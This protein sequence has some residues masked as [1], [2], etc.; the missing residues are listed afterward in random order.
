MLVRRL[1]MSACAI[2]T[3]LMSSVTRAADTRAM[4][5][6]ILDAVRTLRGTVVSAVPAGRATATYERREDLLKFDL[7]EVIPK[8][9]AVIAFAGETS[10]VVHYA[11][12]DKTVNRVELWNSD[13][14][15]DY[16]AAEKGS[17]GSVRIVRTIKRS[18]RPDLTGWHYKDIAKIPNND[19]DGEFFADLKRYPNL[20]VLRDGQSVKVVAVYPIAPE[21]KHLVMANAL[22]Y[23]FDMRY[24][25]MLNRFRHV[26]KGVSTTH[27]GEKRIREVDQV[28]TLSWRKA[29]NGAI[30]PVQRIATTITKSDAGAITHRVTS[31]I[32][33]ADFAL[34]PVS[35]DELTMDRMG[36]PKDTVV[37]D[38]LS[39]LRWKYFPG[40]GAVR[41]S[42]TSKPVV[43]RK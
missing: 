24:G 38:S 33:F 27:T 21:Y 30:L 11:A 6:K 39:G 20:K 23:E 18:F 9:R 16:V 43:E 28:V 40:A 34:E 17:T 35:E 41:R 25:G 10:L 37:V 12:D 15:T 7:V 31:K 2:L 36:I 14:L 32:E 19:D 29:N 3:V 13:S 1:I 22:E 5:D 4:D 26:H 42:S 8:H